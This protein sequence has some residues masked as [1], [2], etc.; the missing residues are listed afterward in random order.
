MIYWLPLS[1]TRE[2]PLIGT[3]GPLFSYPTPYR[4]PPP[5]SLN[6]AVRSCS[7]LLNSMRRKDV[8]PH[9]LAPFSS[10]SR[11][12]G[13][14]FTVYPGFLFDPLHH[15]FVPVA[16]KSGSRPSNDGAQFCV[17]FILSRR[18]GPPFL[19]LLLP[20]SPFPPL[21]NFSPSFLRSSSCCLTRP[22][23]SCVA[24]LPAFP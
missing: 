24:W 3:S 10:W 8:A 13:D 20:T 19:V 22:A 18:S 4:S 21:L 11:F 12:R 17:W 23:P 2:G 7:L 14:T 5:P 9:I 16:F 15:S 1:Y 6:P